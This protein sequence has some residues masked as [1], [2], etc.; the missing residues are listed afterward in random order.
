MAET[1]KEATIAAS[2]RWKAFFNG[3]DAAGC[4]SC[5]EE[6]AKMVATP[7]GTYV[8]RADI[9]AFWQKLIG[10]GFADVDYVD[11]EIEVIDDNTAMLKS[12]WTMNKAHGVITKELWVRQPDGAVLLRED[13]FE[14]LR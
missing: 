13:H 2:Q 14:A 5:Y 7:F 1:M 10:D 12:T 11:P 6:N 8:G 4:A 9:E 3:G